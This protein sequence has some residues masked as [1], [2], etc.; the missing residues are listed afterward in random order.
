M[1]SVQRRDSAAAS[2]RPTVVPL[3]SSTVVPA[4]TAAARL[5]S[6]EVWS[7]ERVV[8][9]ELI[10]GELKTGVRVAGD[11]AQP[12]GG[13]HHS[14]GFRAV[15]EREERLRHGHHTGDVGVVRGAEHVQR[16]LARQHAAVEHD[17]GAVQRNVERG[18]STLSPPGGLA[19]LL[20]ICDI[21]RAYGPHR[22]HCS[23]GVRARGTAVADAEP[24]CFN[25]CVPRG[26]LGTS[27]ARAVERDR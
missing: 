3:E 8:R 2:P 12:A 22:R 18:E 7:L 19:H 27:V 17:P 1:V 9:Q 5:R 4:E 14:A 24:W 10:P 13:I 11:G 15:Q 20:G 23:A 21:Q 6:A 16:D 26:S 25:A